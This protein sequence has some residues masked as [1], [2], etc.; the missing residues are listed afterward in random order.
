MTTKSL[1][2][3]ISDRQQ[4]ST[5]TTALATT[6]SNKGVAEI[7]ASMMIAKSFPRDQ[8]AAMDR[9]LN[10]C[11]R[12]NLANAAVYQYARGG[13]DI[14]G[15]S[16]RL[17]E[18]IAQNWGNISFGIREL[19]S[20]NGEST[21]QAYC[22]DIETNTYRE[23]TFQVPHIRYSKSKG[24]TKLTDPRDIYEL[25]AN[26]GARRLRACILA[27][28]PGDVTEAALE[29]CEL[30]MRAKA[31]TSPEAVQKMIEAFEIGRAHV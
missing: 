12:I 19:E 10:A 24:N 15:P 9:I 5:T 17:A 2:P 18:T 27:I 22:R 4:T 29:Q 28:I 3:F 1:N 23:M 25:I 30:T 16:I 20:S 26:Q 14:T 8:I 13:T 6:D 7:Q 21:V 31:D 11:T